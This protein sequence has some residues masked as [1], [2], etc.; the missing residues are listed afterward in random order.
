MMMITMIYSLN[1]VTNGSGAGLYVK[2]HHKS[3][4][5][6]ELVSGTHVIPLKVK[7]HFLFVYISLN[8]FAT[9]SNIMK[10]IINAA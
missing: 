4:F 2:I 9:S 8:D 10:N 5:I 1:Y 6:N 7:M 3:I